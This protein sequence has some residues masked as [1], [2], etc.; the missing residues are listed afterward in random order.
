MQYDV[1]LSFAGEDRDF[2]QQVAS[3]LRYRGISVFYDGYEQVDLWGKDL[4]VHLDNIYRKAAQYCVIFI[5]RHYAMKLWS[6]HERQSSQARAFHENREYI[7]PARFDDTEIPGLPPTIG[8]ID[9]RQIAP[10]EFAD[11]IAQKL[12]LPEWK[13]TDES[14]SIETG[15]QYMFFCDNHSNSEI[16]WPVSP[17]IDVQSSFQLL[18]TI[19]ESNKAFDVVQVTL[20]CLK[21]LYNP[22]KGYWTHGEDREFDRVYATTSVLT[23]LFQLGLPQNHSLISKSLAYLEESADMSMSNRATIFFQIAF[24]RIKE[25]RAVQFLRILRGYQHKDPDSPVHG[26]FLLP[27]GPE[28]EQKPSTDHWQNHRYHT[29]GASFHACH[30]ADILLHMQSDFKDGRREAQLILAGIAAY[31]ENSFSKHSGFLLDI[32]SQPSKITL[33]SY[34]LAK[35]L[36][37][38]LPPNWLECVH[39]CA[40]ILKQE[41]NWLLRAFGVMNFYYLGRMHNNMDLRQLS[42]EHVAHELEL[43]WDKRSQFLSNARDVSI[44]GRS[45]LYG[46]RF[47]SYDAG[48]YFLHAANKYISIEG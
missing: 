40:T 34:A 12:G 35:P 8:Y 32:Y 20:D 11:M 30:I 43:M 5:S 10:T 13:G 47:F 25:E 4:Y 27:Q 42:S 15:R 29:E 26:S 36:R 22:N 6:N 39:Y 19:Y 46:H 28:I 45:F 7:L 24:H 14:G 23:Y 1:C 33:L 18:P 41:N 9:L 38:A 3:R 17:Y 16:Q 31:F 21:E 44:F 37:I 2:V 48:A